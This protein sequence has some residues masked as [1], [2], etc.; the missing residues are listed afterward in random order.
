[1]LRYLISDR[2][3]AGSTEALLEAIA[4]A[5]VDYVQIREKD[6][7]TRNLMALIR[8]V[9]T[10]GARLL[11]NDRV[12]VAL[13]CGADGVHLRGHS[14]SPALVRTLVPPGFRIAVSCHSAEEVRTAA[15]E[16]ADFAVL[17]PIFPTPSKAGY[18]EPL[19]LRPLHEAAHSVAIPVLALGGV[20]DANASACLRAGAAGIA[21]IRLFLGS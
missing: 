13:A 11:V 21:G 6:L 17:G 12:D 14:I 7:S 3:A 18:G 2:D 15:A 8:R 4:R 16:G 5:E 1:M 10:R 19:G 9:R 20:N